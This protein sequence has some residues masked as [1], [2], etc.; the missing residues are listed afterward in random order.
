M[1]DM[2]RRALRLMGGEV[3]LGGRE[4]WRGR[5]SNYRPN[6]A[7]VVKYWSHSLGRGLLSSAALSLGLSVYTLCV[8]VYFYRSMCFSLSI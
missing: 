1:V 6:L 5:E 2:P 3:V 7:S 8:L 4:P